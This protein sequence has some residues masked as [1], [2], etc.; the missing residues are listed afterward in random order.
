MIARRDRLA[1]RLLVI[2]PDNH[3]L[4]FRFTPNDRPPLWATAGGEVDPGESFEDAARREL[5][6]ETGIIADPGNVVA[7]RESDFVTFAGEPVHAVEHYFAVHVASRAIDLS[8]HTPSE[9]AVMRHH[10]WWSIDD[11]LTA[12][13]TV[14]PPDLATIL[15]DVVN[16]RTQNQD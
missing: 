4:L 2:D 1:A 12:T 6:E 15:S 7:E 5:R 9:Q 3:L 10:L 11:I 16:A 14:Y 8:G 13:E